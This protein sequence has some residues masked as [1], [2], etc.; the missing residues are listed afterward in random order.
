MFLAGATQRLHQKNLRSAHA[1]LD[2]ELPIDAVRD[3]FQVQLPHAAYEHVAGVRVF[4]ELEGRVFFAQL[5]K[6]LDQLV[7][8]P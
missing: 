2:F 6:D 3:D 1:D 7:A 8:L 5:P 4:L